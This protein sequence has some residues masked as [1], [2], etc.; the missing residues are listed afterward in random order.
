MRYFI[1]ILECET[2]KTFC[3]S[4]YGQFITINSNNLYYIQKVLKQL[5]LAKINIVNKLYNKI[6]YAKVYYCT[7]TD[8]FG[9]KNVYRTFYNV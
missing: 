6:H 3:G 4:D 2:N 9:T 5:S 8:Y 7:N 1:E